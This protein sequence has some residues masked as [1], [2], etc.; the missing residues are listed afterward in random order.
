VD[1]KVSLDDIEKWKF[2]TLPGTRTPTS[3]S[4][5]PKPVPIPTELYLSCRHVKNDEE[6]AS[7]T[8]RLSSRQTWIASLLCLLFKPEDGGSTFLQNVSEPL[9]EYTAVT[10]QKIILLKKKRCYRRQ[11]RLDTCPALKMSANWSG[12]ISQKTEDL[13]VE[14]KFNVLRFKLFQTSIRKYFTLSNIR[15]PRY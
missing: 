10:S 4:S 15:R 5:S 8:Q 6:Q 2:M 9:P 7:S 3:R 14:L 13:F 12:W 1:P 11:S